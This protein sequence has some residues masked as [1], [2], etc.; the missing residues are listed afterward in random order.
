[1]VHRRVSYLSTWAWAKN[2]PRCITASLREALRESG[3]WNAPTGHCCGQVVHVK[4]TI[5]LE[6]ETTSWLKSADV[7]GF[8][9]FFLPSVTEQ[10]SLLKGLFSVCL[11]NTRAAIIL[12]QTKQLPLSSKGHA[13]TH[14]RPWDP[15]A[16]SPVATPR[17]SSVTEQWNSLLEVQL[18][19]WA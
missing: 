8:Y 12:H 17:S 3:V 4:N 9:L 16:T 10:A 18:R 6:V 1:M 2:G 13:R 14:T 15:L 19:C 7:P 5:D 11:S